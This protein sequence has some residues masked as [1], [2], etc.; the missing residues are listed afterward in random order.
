MGRNRVASGIIAGLAAAALGADTIPGFTSNGP[1]NFPGF[2][3][4]MAAGPDGN[5]WLTDSD[6]NEIGRVALDGTVT[7][8]YKLGTYTGF[9]IPTANSFPVPIV[10]GPDGNLWFVEQNNGGR[11]GRC[12]LQGI[13]TDYPLPGPSGQ[14]WTIASGRDGNLWLS[15][16]PFDGSHVARIVRV[17][18]QGVATPFALAATISVGNLAAG[19]DDNIWFIEKSATASGIGRI[20][21]DGVITDTW[22]TAKNSAMDLALGP[23]GNIWFTESN[24]NKIGRISPD[25]VVTEFAIPTA[26]VY[27]W[28]I[29]SGVDGNIWFTEYDAQKIAQLIVATATDQGQAT[30][31][32]SGFYGFYEAVSLVPISAAS[33]PASVG[34][35]SRGAGVHARGVSTAGCPKPTFAVRRASS[36]AD[37]A[38]KISAKAPTECADLLIKPTSVELAPPEIRSVCG[39]QSHSG[40]CYLLTVEGTNNGPSTAVSVKFSVH[41]I[42]RQ[43]LQY[44]ALAGGVCLTTEDVSTA[45]CDLPS[46]GVHATAVLRVRLI[47]D[48]H[49]LTAVG[50]GGNIGSTTPDYVPANNYISTGTLVDLKRGRIVALDEEF[51]KAALIALPNRGHPH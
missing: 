37:N 5:I 24:A 42:G 11:I 35:G 12:T 40:E 1:L 39:D 47:P 16:S 44:P 26:G 50:I 4:G 21:P 48:Y 34:I 38:E 45:R 32:D 18:P 15:N 2:A 10:A 20:T 33:A 43:L 27:P 25:Q 31:N 41:V 22:L 8:G 51:N 17:T 29:A 30:F 9:P 49:S 28:G 19:D 23:D 6:R 14:Q 46:L 13:V 36:G 3:R 7:G